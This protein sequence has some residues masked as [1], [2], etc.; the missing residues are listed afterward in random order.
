[1]DKEILK[2]EQLIVDPVNGDCFRACL[3]SLLGIPNFGY[4]PDGGDK[5]WFIK[6]RRFLSTLG[7]SIH[8]E[9]KACWR[10]G[11]WIASV[12]SLNFPDVT[13]AIIMN[14]Q[15][16]YFDPSTKEK[17]PSGESLL[18]K[19]VVLGGWYL[20]VEDFA[21]L[22]NTITDKAPKNE[23][24]PVKPWEEPPDYETPL[25]RALLL[26]KINDWYDIKF[27]EVRASHIT[28]SVLDLIADFIIETKFGSSGKQPKQYKCKDCG[29]KF[30]EDSDHINLDKDCHCGGVIDKFSTAEVSISEEIL[31]DIIF[32]ERTCYT[33]QEMKD[34]YDGK[35]RDLSVCECSMDSQCNACIWDECVNAAK[36]IKAELER[37]NWSQ[38]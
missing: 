20:E 28:V 16:V 6:W 30:A 34:I 32:K 33:Y 36:A 4:F 25:N 10:N 11:Y 13:H 22:S 9:E 8:Y 24:Q 21:K 26:N 2:N 5:D 35:S 7:L 23:L 31:A 19:D 38:G 14:C 17:Y 18:G 27:K 29:A 37:G 1:M 15:E 3:T 12:K